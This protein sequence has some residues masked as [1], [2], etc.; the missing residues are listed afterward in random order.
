[1]L[2][3]VQSSVQ[4]HLVAFFVYWSWLVRQ[5]LA[6][7]N[8]SSGS[9][10]TVIS[11]LS[12][13]TLSVLLS[14]FF[15]LF[16]KWKH[17]H[18]LLDAPNPA[19]RCRMIEVGWGLRRCWSVCLSACLRRGQLWGWVRLLSVF[20]LFGLE[21]HRK[22]RLNSECSTTVNGWLELSCIFFV[23]LKEE[24]TSCW[25]LCSAVLGIA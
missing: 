7:L 3:G 22:W 4:F 24:R 12:R 23:F 11:S 15:L 10:P 21:N 13:S 6:H 5:A 19:V 2:L 9:S 20:I 16:P 1:M 8:V 14:G 17:K 25:V 18:H